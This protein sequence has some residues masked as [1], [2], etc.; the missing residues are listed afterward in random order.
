MNR[1]DYQKDSVVLTRLKLKKLNLKSLKL[2]RK[3]TRNQL[4]Q[5]F[6]LDCK[7]CDRLFQ[8]S[9]L[10]WNPSPNATNKNMK[11]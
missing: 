4:N 2:S 1:L 10:C 7:A 9:Q 6:H 5:S 11:S 8:S 3:I